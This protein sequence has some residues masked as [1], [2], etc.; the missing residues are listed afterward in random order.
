MNTQQ[1]TQWFVSPIL[2]LRYNTQQD[3]RLCPFIA[4][5]EPRGSVEVRLIARNNE[6]L[7][8]WTQRLHSFETG[9]PRRNGV[10]PAAIVASE[11]GDYAF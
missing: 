6:V 5:A 9:R 11:K 7:A 1:A 2:V 8:R 10:S 4:T 3:R